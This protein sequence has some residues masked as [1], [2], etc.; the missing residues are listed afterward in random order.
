MPGISAA[1]CEVPTPIAWRQ[2]SLARRAS[3]SPE[4]V[5]RARRA[6]AQPLEQQQRD[7]VDDQ[8][9]RGD[10]RARRTVCAAVSC[11]SSPMIP[12]GIVRRDQQP[13]EPC[14][15]VVVADLAHRQR[16]PQALDDPH[17]VAPGRTAAARSP[18][19]RCVATGTSG[20][21]CRS[22]GCSSRPAAAARR[23]GRGSRSGTARRCP[24]SAR[25]SP[26]GSRRSGRARPPT[27]YG[28]QIPS[29]IAPAGHTM[30]AAPGGAAVPGEHDRAARTAST[31]QA[32]GR[33]L[34]PVRASD[35]SS[36][37]PLA[38]IVR[39]W[40]RIGC[41]GLRRTARAHR[42]VPRAV[43]QAP[44][45]AD[46]RAVR[47]RDRRDEPAART[48]LDAAR[49]LLRL[50]SARPPRS[51]LVGG[52]CFVLPGLVVMLA[53]SVLFLSGLAALVAARRRHGRRRRRRRRSLS[54]PDWAS[55]LPIWRRA[56]ARPS[57]TQLLAYASRRRGRGGPR[58][59]R[60]RA[61]PARVRRDR[62]RTGASGRRRSRPALMAAAP[63]VGTAAR[64]GPSARSRLP[65]PAR[66][67]ARPLA[68]FWPPPTLA[69]PARSCGPRLKVGAL[70]FGGGFVIVPA[71]AVGRSRHLPLDDPRTVPERGRARTG[72][73]RAG[74]PDRRGRRLRRR[75]APR[76]AAGGAGRLRAL[77][78]L[79]PR[80]RR[81]ASSGCWSTSACSR[82]SPAPPR[83]PPGRSSARPCRSTAALGETLAVRRARGRGRRSARAA[84]RRRAR[85]CC[86]PAARAWSAA[87]LGAPIPR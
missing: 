30:R 80:R 27:A 20:R 19:P 42:P 64:R 66:S 52:L 73:A 36:E 39:E 6:P 41:I 14:V 12:T 79:H 22:G 40:G 49:D 61:R 60:A 17:P 57:R 33:T 82:S 4:V 7:A 69:A 62:A 43:R 23:R 24:A 18:S 81:A 87:L 77:V 58:G 54:A 29:R 78:L 75:R 48:R 8:E 2:L 16:A 35:S 85:P 68:R 28:L 21:T 67:H 55:P 59:T 46:R 15:D 25:G 47:A 1:T 13:A 51:A 84:P 34:S 44:Q 63:L 70:A 37:P 45:V 76:R 53:L 3:T 65:R 50:A 56:R 31:G 5:A 32:A 38:E 83:R 9:G 72:H 71:D 10:L 74:H 26:P 86:S 11:S